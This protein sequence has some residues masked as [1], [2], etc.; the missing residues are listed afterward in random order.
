LSSE[1]EHFA[2]MKITLYLSFLFTNIASR[3]V[4]TGESMSRQ[5]AAVFAHDMPQ[6]QSGFFKAVPQGD[7]G[8]AEPTPAMRAAQA[9]LANSAAGEPTFQPTAIAQAQGHDN[10]SY[11]Q[12]GPEIKIESEAASDAATKASTLDTKF[13][14]ADL[15][16]VSIIREVVA[17]HGRSHFEILSEVASMSFSYGKVLP[18]EY[19]EMRLFDK[20]NLQSDLK[21]FVGNMGNKRIALAVNHNRRFDAILSEKL[22]FYTTF[23]GFGL[24]TIKI[25]ALYRVGL[26]LP[27][28]N[29]FDTREALRDFLL[30]ESNY[31]MF[32]KPSHSSLSLG[33]VGLERLDRET[34]MLHLIN[35]TS[36]AVDALVDDVTENYGDGYLFQELLRPAP[37][38]AEFAGARIGTVRFYTLNRSG[39]K[40]IHRTVVKLPVEANMADNFWRSGNLLAQVD[41]ASGEIVRVVQGSGIN[42]VEVETHPDTGQ[43]L[44]GATIPHWDEAVKLVFWAADVVDQ[45]PLIGWDLA[46]T[47]RGP[48]LVE[49][50]NAPDLRMPQ[51]VERR[52]SLDAN[53]RALIAEREAE[54]K[55]TKARKKSSRPGQRR[56]KLKRY[57]FG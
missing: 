15:P 18:D 13:K 11:S 39:D 45:V 40:Q 55:D 51:L 47:D 32:G 25:K 53:L 30:D 16:L 24:P 22:N 54:Q 56:E 14:E 9:A 5:A 4:F 23:G 52:G 37:R 3:F 2:L 1:C 43:R 7:A 49:A 6:S 8:V 21:D 28:L 20:A 26:E 10:E 42:Q 46:M 41:Q 34:E 38:M 27:G 12:T 57:K 48:V 19:M 35:G 36:I 31:P 44:I 17:K 29:S 33:I 50:N